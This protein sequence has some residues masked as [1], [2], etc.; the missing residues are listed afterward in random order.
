MGKSIIFKTIGLLYL[1]IAACGAMIA[2]IVCKIFGFNIGIAI[3]IVLGAAIPLT[4]IIF[5]ILMSGEKNSKFGKLHTEFMTELSK[6]GYSERFLQI[7]EEAVNAHRNGENVGKVYLKDFVLYACD[8]YTLNGNYNKSL[9][10]ISNL[11]EFDFTG[12]S[13]TFI[14]FGL[15]AMTYYSALMDIYRGLND[16]ASA[17]NMIGRAAFVLNKDHKFET[18]NMGAEAIY[19]NYCMLIE[20]Y[21]RAGEYVQKLCSY[22]SAEAKKYFVRYYIEAEYD[23]YLGKRQEAVEALR[24]MEPVIADSK[25]LKAALEYFYQMFQVRLGLREDIQG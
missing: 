13:D 25:D 14:D 16:K 24:K 4:A 20:D 3:L 19:Y 18:M 22:T 11:N 12:K 15:S 23:L 2:G 7:T 10:L 6:N 8:Y 21:E 5:P 17:S 1:V 9:S